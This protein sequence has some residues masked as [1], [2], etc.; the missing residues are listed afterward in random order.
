MRK[1]YFLAAI[2]SIIYI[3]TS[4]P[5]YNCADWD[6]WARLAVGLIFFQTGGVI[7]HDIFAY[8]ATKDIWIDHEWGSGVVFYALVKQFGDFGLLAFK[9]FVLLGIFW[10]VFELNQKKKTD[11]HTVSPYRIE[12][13]AFFLF[14][15][16]VSFNNT[17]R[18]Q[19]FTY[20]FFALWLYL[21]ELVKQG[22]NKLIW[23]FPFI[24]VIWANV[25]GGFLA[26]LGIT[27]VY[28]IGEAFNKRS[29]LKY[30]GIFAISTLATL[31]N[32][33]G[34]KYWEFIIDAVTMPRPF[35]SEWD[36]ISLLGPFQQYIN[37]KIFI[38]LFI[39]IL[40]YLFIKKFK[41]INFAEIFVI[42]VTLYMSIKHARHMTFFIIA[43]ASYLYYDLYSAFDMYTKGYIAKF[44]NKCPLKLRQVSFFFRH[45]IVYTLII[46]IGYLSLLYIKPQIVVG[47]KRFPAKAVKFIQLNKISGNLLVLYNWGSYALWKLYPQCLIAIDGRYEEVYPKETVDI[48]ARFHYVGSDWTEFIKKYPPDAMLIPLEYDN[49]YNNL[50]HLDGWKR[51]YKDEIAA[52]FIPTSMNKRKWIQVSEKFKP[53]DDK[54]KTEMNFH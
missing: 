12:Y 25:H 37:F 31:I 3:F 4:F 32:P 39:F 48:M 27:V 24:M 29:Y 10:L 40:P 50:L 22:K 9:F 5:K 54:F 47:E 33:Y 11:E 35:V 38:F 16:L 7:K 21:L 28:G 15:I 1:Y 2:L 52:I 34:L 36:P 41:K 51:I 30:F 53:E 45:F 26:G 46:S 13:Y 17:I 42:L 23:I 49:L 20:L 43:F 18:S 14:S 6:L 19:S 44:Y 8:T